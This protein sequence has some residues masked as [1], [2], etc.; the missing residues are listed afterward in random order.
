MFLYPLSNHIILTD[1]IYVA[2]G[3][4]T[5]S[6]TQAQREAAYFIAERAVCEDISTLLLPVT[7]TGTYTWNEYIPHLVTE[8]AYVNRVELVRFLNVEEEIYY[9]VTGTNN[10][11]VSLRD[12]TYGIIDVHSL[13]GN[14]LCHSRLNPY[15]YHIQV[16]YQA[17]LPTGT[18]NLPD[19]L[20]ALTTYAEIVVNEIIG[21]GN[22][23]PGAIGVE[24]FRNQGYAEVRKKLK[25]T[26]F[27]SS[28]KAQF[29]D[30]LLSPYRKLRY[31]KLGW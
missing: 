21:F 3:G 1:D 16:V 17:G 12:D 10:V 28:A 23:A 20:L 29:I 6:S 2:Y 14:C 9:T 11:H 15:P 24:S 26:I 30:K 7:V 25:N 4:A 18:A 31:V 5:G 27:G 22:E 19:M 8:W 13:F